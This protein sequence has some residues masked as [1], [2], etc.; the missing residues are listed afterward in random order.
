MIYV[1]LAAA[2]VSG[3]LLKE[4]VDMAVILA[5]VVAN[6]I[7]G[8]VQEYRAEQA[9]MALKRLSAPTVR[10]RR[11]GRV[12]SQAA[13]KL[14]P[15][16]I[17]LIEGGRPYLRRCPSPLRRLL[18]V[19]EASLTGEA[20]ASAKHVSA[21]EATG[22]GPGDQD[23]MI[24][25]G[26][27][28]EKGRGEAVVV[29][30]G[31]RTQIGA[32]ATMLEEAEEAET[33]LQQELK[34]TGKR[35]ALLCLAICALIFGLGLIEGQEWTSL[36]LFSVSLA[37]AAIPGPGGHRYRGPLPGSEE[38]G[39]EKAIIRRLAAVE[40]LGSTSVI[41]T[42]KT[43]TLTRSEMTARQIWRPEVEHIDLEAEGEGTTP[44]LP[45]GPSWSSPPS[46]TT[47]GGRRVVSWGRG[48]RSDCSRWPRPL[49]SIASG[50]PCSSPGWA[51]YPSR[52]TAR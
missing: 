4:Y 41:C 49:I 21:L 36:F 5:I 37:V 18:R 27:Y 44:S 30:T 29:E 51:R 20:E 25:Q 3:A 23:N 17:M 48:R 6:S 45:P 35:I 28:V 43:G 38:D 15:G 33:P 14:V 39:R 47:P 50:F 42:D 1:L 9:L 22:L 52:A 24:F 12:E 31:R 7:L 16:D 40:T 26:T 32:I 8:F 34:V 13:E 46:A 10:V 11:A 2:V 19:N